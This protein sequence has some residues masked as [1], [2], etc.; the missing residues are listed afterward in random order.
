[1][2]ILS[3]YDIYKVNLVASQ[4]LFNLVSL[5]INQ[6]FDDITDSLDQRPYTD[7]TLTMD[8]LRDDVADNT[9]H[10]EALL[11]MAAGRQGDYYSVP[12]VNSKKHDQA[13]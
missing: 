2:R 4:F 12:N 1:M 7:V 5:V 11:S 9:S 8:S 13:K 10:K 6:G 3:R